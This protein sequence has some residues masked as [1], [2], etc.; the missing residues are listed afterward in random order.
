MAPTV[1]FRHLEKSVALRF[2]QIERLLVSFSL[3]RTKLNRLQW[4][5]FMNTVHWTVFKLRIWIFSFIFESKLLRFD[6]VLVTKFIPRSRLLFIMMNSWCLHGATKAVCVTET[7]PNFG[8]AE[9]I[10]LEALL[11]VVRRR[12]SRTGNEQLLYSPQIRRKIHNLRTA[13]GCDGCNG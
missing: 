1:L 3:C 4:S 7:S 12:S 2:G 11:S 5:H 9:S 8:I 6:S 13:A 10:T